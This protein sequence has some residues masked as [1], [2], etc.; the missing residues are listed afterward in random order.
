MGE[1]AARLA[2]FRRKREEEEVSFIHYEHF[3]S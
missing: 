2:E 1:A 3:S